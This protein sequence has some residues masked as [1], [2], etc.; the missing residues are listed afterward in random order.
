MSGDHEQ[1]CALDL[2]L[3]SVTTELQLNYVT[4]CNINK[5]ALHPKGIILH[6]SIGVAYHTMV[7]ASLYLA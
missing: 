6:R 5:L 1:G 4:M 2:G 7:M 3:H